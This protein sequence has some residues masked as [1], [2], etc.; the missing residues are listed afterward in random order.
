MEQIKSLQQ[1]FNGESVKAD[2]DA[3]TIQVLQKYLK[4]TKEARTAADK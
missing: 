4:S 3:E 1:I 2:K